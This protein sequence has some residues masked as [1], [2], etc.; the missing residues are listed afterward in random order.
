MGRVRRKPYRI[1][2]AY[3][4]ETANITGKDIYAYPV[5]HQLGILDTPIIDI[6]SDNV[7]Q[8]THIEL[9][10]HSIDLYA[11]LD[12]IADGTYDYVPVICC[13]NLSFDMY[14]L[15]AYLDG[16]KNVRVLAK[17]Q[18]K[19]ITFTICDDNNNPRLV[20]WD[21]L[22][23]SQQ[24][25]ARMGE[26]C[27]YA[28][29]VGEWDYDLIRTPDT[30]LSGEEIDYACKDIYA[31][32]AWLGWW[33]RRNPDIAPEKL[34]LNV[35]SKTGVV[36][37]RRKVR[38]DQVKGKHLKY[39]IGRYWHYLNKREQPKDDDELSTMMAATRGGFTF[40]ASEHASQ[41]YDLI[42]SGWHVYGF[43][44]TSMHPSHMVSHLYPV[45]FHRTTKKALDNVLRCIEKT[46]LGHM[47]RHWHKPFNSGIYACYEFSDLK[48]KAGSLY[49]EHGIFPLASARFGAHNREMNEDNQDGQEFNEQN[50]YKDYAEDPIFL[51]GKLVSAKRVRVY[52]TELA[53][54]EITQAYDYSSAK[55]V[56]GYITGRFARP[57]DMSIIS[58]M[59]FYRAKNLYKDARHIYY[60]DGRIAESMAL[61]L[62]ST[63]IPET[64][65]RSMVSGSISDNDVEATYLGLKA[66][67]NALFGIECSNEYRRDTV[68]TSSGIEYEGAFG[69]CNAPKNPKAWYQFGQRI[70]GWSR[71][72]QHAMMQLGGKYALDIINGD[73]DSIKLLM[74][75]SNL[76][77]F[78]SAIDPLHRAID[79]AKNMVCKRVKR[80]YPELYDSLDGI[81]HYVQEFAADR[82]CASW[83]KAYVLHDIDKR[84]G[85]RHF[86][87]TIA[88][89]P[90]KRGLNQLADSLYE[91]GKS[92]GYICNHILGYNVTIGYDLIRL[93]A[94]KFPWWGDMLY[95]HV[96]DY[97]GKES[98]V[99]EC[100]ALALYPMAK[101]INDTSNHENWANGRKAL[102]NNPG[103][104]VD[105]LII[106]KDGFRW[107]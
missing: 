80:N 79:R 50:E 12:M 70:V 52:V 32:L 24:S 105:D 43:D 37:E 74:H 88:G 4:S 101:T 40:C 54:W 91:H 97:M 94:R 55:A 42:D 36:R 96:V 104:N 49:S 66:D 95:K 15:S 89:I 7:E 9:F 60:R 106:T 59:Q 6:G 75:D 25:L 44:A 87:F 17:S 77:D 28:K 56:H 65:C 53:L 33:L 62:E 83:N 47:L 35:V 16:R 18:R 57:S 29:A 73:T 67:L 51:F 82:F 34:G 69:I 93:H 31:L 26:D 45:G 86:A 99:M 10:R 39:N 90:A 84:D 92:F 21:T 46:T 2:G 13:H 61:D 98:T 72:A 41:V 48:P 100:A 85:K 19:P 68:L 27:G 3:D 1:I 5:L 30:P 58:V 20:L 63:G 8:H 71:I 76:D 103:V 64:I 81:G 14:G 107:L 23:F 22:I 78:I 102:Q 38:F 11:A